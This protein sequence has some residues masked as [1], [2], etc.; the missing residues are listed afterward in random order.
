MLLH[1]QF[2]GC[3]LALTAE[4]W[5]RYFKRNVILGA[6]P[7][8]IMRTF[9]PVSF[10]FDISDTEG[11][12]VPDSVLHPFK[13]KGAITKRMMNTLTHNMLREG[14]RFSEAD[15]A[16]FS[17]GF[18]AYGGI[19]EKVVEI[20]DRGR[21]VNIWTIFE[22]VVNKNNEL[23]VRFATVLHELGHFYCGHCQNKKAKWLPHRERLSNFQVEFE[24]ESVS[25]LVCERLGIENHAEE[26]LAHYLEHEAQIP[27]ISIDTVIKAVGKIERLIHS[28]IIPRK[29][30]II[31]DGNAN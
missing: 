2:P 3:Q 9:G 10:V 28:S 25:W 23:P 5:R 24:A 11:D 16:A 8:I 20:Q 14:I 19:P 4:E 12:P 13:T 29:E 22:I 7:L 15:Q 21:K 18:I 6:R 31:K 30:L 1:M 26:Y 17:G 27:D